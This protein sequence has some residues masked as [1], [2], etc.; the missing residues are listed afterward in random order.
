MSVHETTSPS[1]PMP[2]PK[3]GH[4]RGD[5]EQA[6]L[7]RNRGGFGPGPGLSVERR[8][9]KE[10]EHPFEQVEW[11][12]RTAGI[13]SESGEVV[14][15]QTD[16]EAPKSWSQTATNIVAQK[17]F[18][19]QPG[20]PQRE[21]SVKQLISRVAD[22]ITTWGDEGGYFHTPA[23]R[24]AFR[25]ELTFLLLNQRVAFNSPVWFNCGIEEQPQVSACFIN[26]VQDSMGS[27]LDLAKTEGM[28]FKFGSGTGSNLSALRSSKELL[29]GGGTAS[30]P[31]SFMRGYDAF[32]GVIKSGGKTRRAAKMV[33]LNSDHP[34]IVEF[35]DCKVS[36]ERKARTLINAGYDA[37][38]NVPG[39]AYDSVFFQNANHSVRVTDEFMRAYAEDREW[40]TKA[41]TSGET[42]DTLRARDV[43]R[44][45]AEA[46]WE[47]GDPGIQ[48]DSTINSWHTC[49]ASGRINS[50]NPCS[51]YMF[52]DDTACNLA[53]LN[54]MKFLAPDGSF[55]TEDFRHAV[56][57]TT[58]AQEILVDFASY[59]TPKITENS[60]RYRPLG[61][62]F[63]N[64]G[65]SLMALGLPY[66]SEAGRAFAAG[67]T[68]LM[69][70]E[71]YHTSARVAEYHG[72]PFAD[73]EPNRRAMLDVVAKHR[74]HAESLA[75]DLVPR[76]LLE[77]A[78]DSW[79]RA[80]E[81]GS[82]AGFRNS[83]L[84]VLAPTGTIAFMMDCDTTG[85]EPD[86]A[87]IKYKKLVG[88]GMIR[89]VNNTVPQALG[90]LGYT[91][92]QAESILA[93]IT[94]NETVE[95]APEFREEHLPVFDCS[96]RAAKGSRTIDWMGHLRMMAAVQP[97]LS[98][99]ISKTVNLPTDAS[100]EDV[101]KAYSEAWRLG[102]KAVA[103]YRDG[104]K[105]TQPLSTSMAEEIAEGGEKAARL[106]RKR[107]PD[108]REALTHKFSVAGH[109]GYMTVGLYPDTGQP[110]EIFVTMAK[111][112]SVVSGLMDSFATSISI[113]LQYGVPLRVLA[114]KFTHLRFEPAGYTNN[115]AIP[116]AK[117]IIDYMFRWLA[118]KFLETEIAET[119][120]KDLESDVAKAE[121]AGADTSMQSVEKEVFRV[122]SDAPPCHVCGTIMVRNGACYACINC[123]ATSGCS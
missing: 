75:E 45:M 112:G 58:L 64:L 68:A 110:G 42:V 21:R 33:I 108:E 59:P 44:S 49:K 18:R 48:F 62:G 102:L 7:V 90:R 29:S 36:E 46:A 25:D 118:L 107:L 3:K 73:F 40:H 74:L 80:E 12:L 2:D 4:S 115:R 100:V 30:G 47:C 87:L 6:P 77:A 121:A 63:A 50:S 104:C 103:I 39:G 67:V 95:G 60:F 114:D 71:A 22:T 69:C 83:Q 109:E 20:T 8:F 79:R 98:G 54:L 35:I 14:F 81:V 66:D 32:A 51:E 111:Q 122:Q 27:I 93:Y 10:G 55:Q 96:F 65:A 52:L 78:R 17:Y 38:F 57:T 70:G 97:F 106:L 84:T 117:S 61:L 91:P 85:I 16:V 120:G 34:D 82:K 13:T 72:G 26:S 37:G 94:E 19:G 24:E 89:I 116:I 99:A 113:A 86:L 101:E 123:G 43:M 41:V 76:Q 53:S 56:A 5:A 9:T 31:V 105:Q 23:D 119:N 1:N 11:E 15:E 88:G 92:D 28:L